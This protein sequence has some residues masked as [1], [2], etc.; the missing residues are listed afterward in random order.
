MRRAGTLLILLLTLLVAGCGGDKH[1][2]A[3]TPL[4]DAVGYFAKDAPFVAA[5]ETNPD[6]RDQAGHRP[7]RGFPGRDILAT[8]LA[9][10]SRF[11]FVDWNRDL[12]PQLGAPLVVGLVKP[13]AGKD[14]L[15]AAVAAMRL[16]HPVRAKPACSRT[17]GVRV[18]STTSTVGTP[19]ECRV[20][21]AFP[22]NPVLLE[23][24]LHDDVARV[25]ASD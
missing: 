24:V 14:L 22:P 19:L 6:A 15:V 3:A 20:R 13:A 5:V 9:N 12:R 16:K 21:S 7:R 1:K 4:D 2:Q 23:Y 10:L 11:H 8:R 17:T 25:P 18:A